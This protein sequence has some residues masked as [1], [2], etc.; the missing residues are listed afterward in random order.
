MQHNFRSRQGDNTARCGCLVDDSP[1]NNYKNTFPEFLVRKHCIFFLH[2]KIWKISCK[3]A[4]GLHTLNSKFATKERDTPRH[5]TPSRTYQTT[6]FESNR[7]VL[8]NDS[9]QK[10][11]LWTNNWKLTNSKKSLTWRLSKRM[12][13][14]VVFDT[15][16]QKQPSLQLLHMRH[17]QRGK[18]SGPIQPHLQKCK[19]SNTWSTSRN[20][21]ARFSRMSASRIDFFHYCR[22]TN[23]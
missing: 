7:C 2:H 16:K 15:T 1:E 11:K 14:Q 23:T 21:T 19:D 22:N 12:T 8:R 5:V 10:N 17:W 6:H 3:N 9:L 13:A 18:K 20:G 4:A